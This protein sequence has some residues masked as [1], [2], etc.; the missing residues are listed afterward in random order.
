MGVLQLMTVDDIF[1][2]DG[3]KIILIIHFQ[4]YTIHNINEHPKMCALNNDVYKFLMMVLNR[5]HNDIA[6][7]H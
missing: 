3:L 6:Q 7:G 2:I 5:F 4:T 1:M